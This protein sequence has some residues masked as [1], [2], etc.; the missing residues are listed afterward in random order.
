MRWG[1]IRSLQLWP[2]NVFLIKTRKGKPVVTFSISSWCCKLQCKGTV[3]WPPWLSEAGKYC[4]KHVPDLNQQIISQSF[5]NVGAVF[6]K[7]MVYVQVL[8]F[9]PHCCLLKQKWLSLFMDKCFVCWINAITLC[10][11]N[12]YL[13]ICVELLVRNTNFLTHCSSEFPCHEE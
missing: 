7:V 6:W 5:I 4:L 9:F 13:S 8:G 1:W 11:Q 10:N 3:E 12:Q 2:Y